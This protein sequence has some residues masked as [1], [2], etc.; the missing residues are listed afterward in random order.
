MGSRPAPLERAVAEFGAGALW[1]IAQASALAVPA[2][3]GVHDIWAVPPL[4]IAMVVFQ[5]YLYADGA[6]SAAVQLGVFVGKVHPLSVLE[7]ARMIIATMFGSAVGAVFIRDTLQWLS[8]P[9]VG[10]R[11]PV[12]FFPEKGSE[13]IIATEFV[14]SLLICALALL[15]CPK[16]MIAGLAGL[17]IVP[18]PAALIGV[19][20]IDPAWSFGRAFAAK[21]FYNNHIYL[22]APFAGAIAFGL[23]SRYS[24]SSKKAAKGKGRAKTP[25]KKKN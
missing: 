5:L 3:L 10:M 18:V 16:N 21:D 13:I 24:N 17:F 14:T 8:I 6:P 15:L 22:L 1:A 23:Y 2:A 4:V 12:T 9:V 11:P 20:G 25:K 19:P 7:A